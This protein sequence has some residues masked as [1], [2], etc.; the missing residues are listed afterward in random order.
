MIRR[1]SAIR[2]ATEADA[3]QIAAI[4]APYVRETAI[5]F[6]T[7]PP[8]PGAMADRIGGLAPMYPW[9]ACTDAAEVLG[10]AYASRHRDRAAYQWSIDV[11][12]YV[13][14]AAH[15]CGVGRALYTTLLR[16]SAAQGYYN[17]YAGITL[18]NAS[19][20]GLH[21]AMGFQP[22]GI[23][24]RVGHK[25]GA[26]HDVGW[27]ALDLQ[28]RPAT[29]PPPRPLSALLDTAEWRDAVAAGQVLLRL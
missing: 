12:V 9:L 23:Y 28:P 18:P 21:E 14:A 3:E 10:Y 24:Q 20:V 7:V 27:W 2:Q 1:M 11:S 19:S 26:W 17:A 16:L 29:P 6:E 5:S 13:A 4:Y 25:L 15:R 8:T 22:L